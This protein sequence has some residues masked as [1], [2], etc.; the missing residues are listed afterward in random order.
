[1]ERERKKSIQEFPL[2]ASYGLKSEAECAREKKIEFRVSF[3]DAA[4]A[5]VRGERRS[6]LKGLS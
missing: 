2:R 5:A 6:D 1:M 4:A 3:I